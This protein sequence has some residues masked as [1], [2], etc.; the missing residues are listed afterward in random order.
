LPDDFCNYREGRA[1]PAS[2][3]NLAPS[4]TFHAKKLPFW[5]ASG[6]TP[7]LAAG[8]SR[9]PVHRPEDIESAAPQGRLGR[10]EFRRA[11]RVA[12][13]GCRAPG[14]RPT[15]DLQ[16]KASVQPSARTVGLSASPRCLPST[17]SNRSGAVLAAE[18]MPA[19]TCKNKYPHGM[20][21][22]FT[23]VPVGPLTR[24]TNTVSGSRPRRA[25]KRLARS[26]QGRGAPE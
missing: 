26:W 18:P 16:A 17:G 21:A 25:S 1:H 3:R 14:E 5:A 10:L 19:V 8:A 9:A 23:A 7:V 4:R 24:H 20:R 13:R 6:E 15:T 22:F 12:C 11:P 2:P